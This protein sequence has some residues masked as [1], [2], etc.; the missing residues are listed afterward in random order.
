VLSTGPSPGCPSRG[1]QKSQGGGTFLNTLLN[2]CSNR[3]EKS[4]WRYVN[5]IHF[6][7]DKESYAD[8]VKY[9]YE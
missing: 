1:C 9:I 5:F 8:I 7:L 3:H 2:A 4:R 6:K